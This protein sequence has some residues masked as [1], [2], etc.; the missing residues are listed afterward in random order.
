MAEI[1]VHAD[2]PVAERRP[3]V[4]YGMA[5][6][7]AALFGVNGS[8]A[9][10]AIRSGVPSDRLTEIRCAGA[11]VGLLA[12]AAL[13]HRRE[14]RI[15]IRELPFLAA[16][17]IGG[18]AVVQWAYFLAI[19]RIPVGVALVIQYV[20]PLLVA[21]YARFVLRE[22][23]RARVWMALALSL[24]GLAL[25]VRIWHGIAFDGIGMLAAVASTISFAFYLLMA[26]RGI[27]RRSSVPLLAW[28]FA[29]AVLFWTLTLPW[30]SYPAGTLTHSTSLLG[31]LGGLHVPLVALVAW[32]IVLGT[33]VPFVLIVGALRHAPATRV[34]IVAMLEPVTATVVAWLWLDETLAPV[35]LVGAAVVLTGILVA[36][37]AR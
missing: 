33:I 5:A 29:F 16:F 35:Q 15:R 1:I 17:G 19:G 20:A 3:L 2:Q 23:V 21:L 26:E 11:L 8:V 13:T 36:Q 7:A 25:V 6:A 37:S 31:R 10:V 28:G 27:V 18:V 22:H 12:L 24:V 4:G 32:V 34:G 30:W 9:K 14:L